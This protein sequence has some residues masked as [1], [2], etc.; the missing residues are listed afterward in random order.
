VGDDTAAYMG[1]PDSTEIPFEVVSDRI[2]TLAFQR[3]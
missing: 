1:D 2:T 3:F